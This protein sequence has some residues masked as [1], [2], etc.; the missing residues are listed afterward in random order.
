MVSASSCFLRRENKKPVE[1][2]LHQE[3]RSYALIY[4]PSLLWFFFP[5][6]PQLIAA[7]RSYVSNLFDK[8]RSKMKRKSDESRHYTNC[9]A[10]IIILPQINEFILMLGERIDNLKK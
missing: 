8:L 9:G 4:V 5:L 2:L 10:P 1:N 7:R 6:W 3:N